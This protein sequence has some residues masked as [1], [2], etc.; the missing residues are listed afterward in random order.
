MFSNEGL[1]VL[2]IVFNCFHN[3][4][5]TQILEIS[6]C[7]DVWL[8]YKNSKELMSCDTAFFFKSNIVCNRKG[9]DRKRF[10]W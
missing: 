7:E 6:H 10:N 8:Q 5:A 9:S 2:E 3:M 1:S 4:T